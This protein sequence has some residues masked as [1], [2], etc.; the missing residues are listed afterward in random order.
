MLNISIIEMNI[1]TYVYVCTYTYTYTIYFTRSKYF[2][3]KFSS[4]LSATNLRNEV[5]KRSV[6]VEVEWFDLRLKSL[7]G[8]C[9]LRMN[10]LC[11]ER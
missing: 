7:D 8:I 11:N 10:D 2:R 3:A 4:K 9:Y 5:R 6:E 1:Y